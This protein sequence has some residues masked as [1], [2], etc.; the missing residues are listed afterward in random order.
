MG[1]VA[2]NAGA[3]LAAVV[4]VLVLAGGI[5]APDTDDNYGPTDKTMG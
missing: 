5:A 2:R 3:L 4:V 1:T